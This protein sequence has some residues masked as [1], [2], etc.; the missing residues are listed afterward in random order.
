MAKALRIESVPAS[1]LVRIAWTGGGEV[2]DELK[3]SYTSRT[4]AKLAIAAWQASNPDREVEVEKAGEQ[5]VER[6][7]KNPNLHMEPLK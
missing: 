1:T 2:P 7:A 6:K 3:G 5:K 4:N